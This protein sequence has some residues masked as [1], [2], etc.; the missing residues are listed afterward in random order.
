[1]A[2]LI[3]ADKAAAARA[4][5]RLEATGY[6][7]RRPDEK[8]G[9]AVRVPH[10]QGVCA[11]SPAGAGRGEQHAIIHGRAHQRRTRRVEPPVGQDGRPAGEQPGAV[12]AR[13]IRAEK[14]G[15]VPCGTPPGDQARA[16]F[17]RRFPWQVPVRRLR[18]PAIP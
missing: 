16:A 5:A 15:G 9:R 18:P 11:A 4:L 13:Y 2:H 7:V 8:D 6:I 17:I 3:G 12:G 14:K 1:M 10:D